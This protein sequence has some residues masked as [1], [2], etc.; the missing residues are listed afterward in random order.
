M[1]RVKVSSPGKLM[2]MGD[3]AVVHDRQC[4]VTAVNQRLWVTI[5]ET[6]QTGEILIDAPDVGLDQFV[7]SL[8][9]GELTDLPK[10]AKFVV[11][12]I[13]NFDQFHPVKTGLHLTTASDFNATFGFGSSSAVTVA[14]IKALAELQQLALSEA[15]LFKLA[16]QTVLDI[17]GVG[18]GFDLAAAIWGGTLLFSTGGKE[19]RP[20]VVKNLPL[21]VGYTGVKADT[22]TLVKQVGGF[23]SAAPE[24]VTPIFDT[25][26][27]SVIQAEQD[28]E[29]TNWAH[30][31]QLMNLHQGLLNA[32]GVSSPELERLVFAARSA[33]AY[34]AKLSGAGGG[35]CMIALVDNKTRSVV[36]E[37]IQTAGG[38]VLP[39]ELSAPGIKVEE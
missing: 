34:G 24:L 14:S 33:G 20:L 9:Q 17:Q 22:A 13:R 2:L 6:S 3:H 39:V 12:A 15:Q 18:S 8:K 5:E 29:E 21:V 11:Q 16:Y 25:I 30:L 37:A 27:E 10:A 36:E 23:L 32:L 7:V 26:Q 38:Q 31:G 35:D 1:K 4:L 28:L 19:I